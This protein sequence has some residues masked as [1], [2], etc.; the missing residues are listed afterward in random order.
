MTNTTPA[1]Q[2]YPGTAPVSFHVYADTIGTSAG[3]EGERRTLHNARRLAASLRRAG[4]G[5][6]VMATYHADGTSWCETVEA[7][8]PD[9]A[10]LA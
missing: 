8:K 7:H 10:E 5:T 3:Y 9:G 1:K 6:C 2:V 4:F